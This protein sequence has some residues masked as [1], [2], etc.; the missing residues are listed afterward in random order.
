MK[1]SFFLNDVKLPVTSCKRPTFKNHAGRT[2]DTGKI[3][4]DGIRHN[5]HL[6]TSWGQFIYFQYGEKCQWKKVRIFSEV[7]AQF[8]GKEYD[9]D[10]FSVEP[11]EITTK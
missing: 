4:I 10:P 11:I 9:I 3:M 6:D 5:A 7:E 2:W 1:K 8:K